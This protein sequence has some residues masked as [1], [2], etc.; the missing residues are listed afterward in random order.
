[1]SILQKSVGKTVD[2]ILWVRDWLADDD[3]VNAIKADLGIDPDTEIKVPEI[4]Q[5]A[6]DSL[7]RYRNAS[8]PNHEAFLETFDD[9]IAV[10]EV[11]ANLKDENGRLDEAIVHGVL[12]L[13]ITNWA[14]FNLPFLY[15]YVEPVLFLEEIA[16]SDPIVKGNSV[17]FAK[18]MEKVGSFTLDLLFRDSSGAV[19]RAYEFIKNIDEHF[20]LKTEA[21]AR[22][23]S[24]Y[25]L[26]PLA[27]ALGY[28]EHALIKK[29]IETPPPAARRDAVAIVDA[30]Y[31]W[32]AAPVSTTPTADL[33]ADRTLTFSVIGIKEETADG[34]ELTTSGSVTMTW[35]PSDHGEPGLLMAFGLSEQV[36]TDLGNEWKLTFKL[37]SAA[38]LDVLIR[39]GLPDFGGPSEASASVTI[40]QPPDDSG[41]PNVF[42][43]RE[44]TRIECE[45]FAIT[46]D[47]SSRGAEIRLVMQ[48]SALVIAASKDGDGFIKEILPKGETR[49]SFDLGV[50]LSSERGFYI[51]GG[52]GLE[53]VLPI[54]KTL[55]P[56]TVHQILIS[57]V[58]TT[59]AKPPHIK[60]EISVAL[61]FK[62]GPIAASVDRIGFEMS[63]EFP[64]KKK[65]DFSI[66]FKP[67]NG[68]GL[69]IDAKGVE[70]GGFLFFDRD[71]GQYAGVLEV[72][73]NLERVAMTL[74]AIGLLNTR[75]PDGKDG[76]SLIVILTAEFKWPL[77]LGF[78]LTGFGIILGI[79]RTFNETA[80]Q[81]G[82]KN[83]TLDSILFPKDPVRNAPALLATLGSVF[84]IAKGHHFI[85]GMVQITW[86]ESVLSPLLTMSLG[87]A[88][89]FGE[90]SRLLV[91]GQI[92]SILPTEKEDLVRFH[93]DAIGIIDFD[94][95]TASIDAALYDSRLAKTFAIS[96][97]MA[98]RSRW[99]DSPNFALAIGGFHPAF[100]PP[101]AFPKVKRVAINLSKG[102]NPR[103]RCEAYFALTSNTI[104]F[105]A[106]AE[107][108]A[109]AA[110]FSISGAIGFDVLIQRRPFHFTA[111]FFA[112]VQLKRGN[113]NLFKVRVEGSLSGP[114]PLHVKGKA[115]F[116]ILWWDYSV[117]FDKTLI[118][119]EKPPLPEVV[120]VMPLL[121]E[122]LGQTGNWK[123]QL[124]DRQRAMVTLRPQPGAPTDVLLHP[125][126]TM[127][128]KQTVVPLNFEISKFGPSPPS[129]T[130]RF[131]IT[132]VTVGDDSN[133]TTTVPERDFFAPAQFIEM[134]DDQKLSRPSFDKMEAG[135]T[136][137]SSVFQ[138]PESA[139]D[140][141]VV[142]TVQFETW[143]I[144][145]ET[146]A[147]RPADPVNTEGKKVLYQMDEKLFLKQARFGAAGSSD[148]RRSGK[149]RY[150]TVISKYRVEKEGWTIFDAENLAPQVA[151]SVSYSEAAEA[152]RKVKQADPE[153]AS[154]LKILRGSDLKVG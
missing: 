92:K 45:R 10:I 44:S 115:T 125:L 141:I 40:E 8:N 120:E 64:E 60:S 61:G 152:L 150:R 52:T 88:V 57:L 126:G 19:K 76:F 135:V 56:L 106:R 122:A 28:L 82:V 65:P 55:G 24:D 107:L 116:E 27:I 105:G 31:G 114:K 130:R 153:R 123:S 17:A 47:I 87:I 154:G 137:G 124:P 112:Q 121:R 25:T 93:L 102:D 151:R 59:E 109:S 66:G 23:L 32:D 37:S 101:P 35:V 95:K 62:L 78:T 90:R 16:T 14:R 71:K 42:P 100:N 80:L 34:S 110:G 36:E 41:L 33:I 1:M 67:P 51:E 134:S 142:N 138:I 63:V 86:G 77:G 18:G 94:Q 117:R 15:W 147:P 149:A 81:A 53:A 68:V 128:I 38:A 7:Q 9:L 75:L 13:L 118:E 99:G 54:A 70:G 11:L 113:T 84:P 148:L 72:N 46:G 12:G 74:K 127:T 29:Q 20:P 49:I 98:M 69:V 89:E 145:K 73:L 58:A 146:K 104:Q 111:D 79:H 97:E 119:G 144:D 140:R 22:R 6:L 91:M 139:E 5:E 2:L 4:P 43:D 143:I 133:T 39:K 85:G 26:Q 83:H 129:G 48:N 30:I 3:V 136:F 21:D 103:L 108:F 96:G 50:G 131:S 132:K